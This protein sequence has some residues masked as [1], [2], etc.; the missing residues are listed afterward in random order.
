M[1]GYGSVCDR[2]PSRK[3]CQERAYSQTAAVQALL[4]SARGLLTELLQSFMAA[5]SLRMQGTVSSKEACRWA[6]QESSVTRTVCTYLKMWKIAAE[7]FKQVASS[8]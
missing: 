2:S 5:I 1:W 7:I 4:K 3:E 8:F 6:R